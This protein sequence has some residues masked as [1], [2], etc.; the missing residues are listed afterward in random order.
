MPT[1]LRMIFLVE[2][3]SV[4]AEMICNHIENRHP[5]FSIRRFATGEEMLPF[6]S[7]HPGIIILDYFLDGT[8]ENAANG[9]VI[10]KAVKEIN[11]ETN[12]IIITSSDNISVAATA[13]NSGANAFVL[14]DDTLLTHLDEMIYG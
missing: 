6:L 5:A 11:P 10:L 12:V 7:A 14:K 2:D 13:L 3:N 8:N 9:G 1:P 4:Y